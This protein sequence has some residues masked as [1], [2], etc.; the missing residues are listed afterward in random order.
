M[1]RKSSTSVTN[2]KYPGRGFILDFDYFDW[3]NNYDDLVIGG[4]L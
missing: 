4:P 3:Q 2:Y 1:E